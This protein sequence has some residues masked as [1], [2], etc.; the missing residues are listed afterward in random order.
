MVGGR[1]AFSA[2]N[3]NRARDPPRDMP[4][5][6]PIKPATGGSTR[7]EVGRC[8]EI[9]PSSFG[10]GICSGSGGIVGWRILLDDASAIVISLIDNGIEI[11]EFRN[12]DSGTIFDHH[13][14]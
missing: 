4:I 7:K 14:R 9:A 2:K 11:L 3:L 5:P 12:L 6:R 13:L 1:C 10:E 8:K